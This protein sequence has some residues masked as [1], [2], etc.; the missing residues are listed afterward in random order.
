MDYIYARGHY[1]IGSVVTINEPAPDFVLPDLHGALH[2]LSAYQGQ[3]VVINFWSAEC[4]W[5]AE[6][7]SETGGRWQEGVVHLRVA[8]NAHE[9]EQ[10]LWDASHARGLDIILKDVA[11][12]VADLYA[13]QTTPHL[14]VVDR[15][16]I[17]RYQGAFS[18]RT[19]RK[20][21]A[22][23]F[24]LADAVEALLAGRL[25]PVAETQPYGCTIVREV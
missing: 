8:A 7:D 11:A 14:F 25:P 6:S 13:A 21:T 2:R 9:T 15:G 5:S 20:R 18:D 19:F 16:G 12:K 17:L 4:P 10:M 23:T 22:S 1:I 3:V 24:Y